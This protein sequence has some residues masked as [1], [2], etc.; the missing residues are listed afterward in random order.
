VSAKKRAQ[1]RVKVQAFVV[2]PA[3][4]AGAAKAKAEVSLRKAVR[5]SFLTDSGSL[6]L[7]GDEWD[8]F[9]FQA[10]GTPEKVGD[11]E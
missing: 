9:G 2:V 10:V 3:G 11:D 8:G 5:E 1:Y 4:S 7:W 6:P